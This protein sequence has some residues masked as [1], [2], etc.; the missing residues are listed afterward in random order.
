MVGKK[1][2]IIMVTATALIGL[3]A[4]SALVQDMNSD[5]TAHGVIVPDKNEADVGENITF[6][7]QDMGIG[8]AITTHFIVDFHDGTPPVELR[9]EYS[10]IHS[11]PF[12]G[13]YGITMIAISPYG[14]TETTSANIDIVNHR[15]AV[16]IVAPGSAVEDENITLSVNPFINSTYPDTPNDVAGLK[17]QWRYGD[18]CFG[19]GNVTTKSYN[20]SG[21]YP[22]AV[23]VS[24][25]QGAIGYA[26][27]TI[28]INNI[29][30]VANFTWSPGTIIEDS[31]I[32]FDARC[33]TDTPSD[34]GSLAYYWDFGDGHVDKNILVY[35]TFL[36]SGT[37]PV[38]LV[39]ID[40]D[41]A[42]DSIVKQVTVVNEL[43]TSHMENNSLILNEGD[44]GI[45]AV[46]ANDTTSD[47]NQMAYSWSTGG[48]GS[49]ATQRYTDEWN[50]NVV[51]T[52]TDPAG[53]QSTATT[54]VSVLNTNPVIMVDS[55]NM[56]GNI[57]LHMAGTMNNTLFMRIIKNGQEQAVTSLVRNATRTCWDGVSATLPMNFDLSQDWQVQVFYGRLNQS[58]VSKSTGV[59]GANDLLFND[60]HNYIATGPASGARGA[61]PAWLEFQFKDGVYFTLFHVFW[62]W[63]NYSWTWNISPRDYLAT[64]TLTILGHVLDR[65]TDVL[66]ARVT[67]GNRTAVFNA[68]APTGMLN[69][70]FTI[71]GWDNWINYWQAKWTSWWNHW[72][73]FW[74][75]WDDDFDSWFS[76][77]W[78]MNSY[79]NQHSWWQSCSS[80]WDHDSC[81]INHI[82]NTQWNDFYSMWECGWSCWWGVDWCDLADFSWKPIKIQAWDDDGGNGILNVTMHSVNGTPVIDHLSPRVS[83]TVPG[84]QV[85]EDGATFFQ[86]SVADYCNTS[87]PVNPA[88]LQCSWNFGDGT[89]IA[90]NA[91]NATHAW[92][93]AGEYMVEA[94]VSDGY[95]RGIDRAIVT[96][97]D[98]QPYVIAITG[99]QNLTVDQLAN[100]SVAGNIID[101]PSD[102][103]SLRCIWNF[104]DGTFATGDA[105]N[106]SWSSPGFYTITALAIDNN[107][108]VGKNNLSIHVGE[109]L[110]VVS[111]PFGIDTTQEML[112]N[113]NITYGDTILNSQNLSFNW[114]IDGVSY[115]SPR[116]CAVLD[117]GMHNGTFT[118]T[119]PAGEFTTAN[120]NIHVVNIIP[121]VI[122]QDY[123]FYQPEGPITLTAYGLDA[124]EDLGTLSY[125]WT[126]NGTFT[127]VQQGGD[128]SIISWT[129]PHSGTYDCRV[130]V[131]DSHG[132]TTDAQF[133][134]HVTLD[135]D[136][137]GVPN[138][139]EAAMGTNSSSP[140][141]DGDGLS[142]AYEINYSHT[143]PAL[144]DTDGDGLVDGYDPITNTGEALLGTNPLCNDTDG[145][146]LTDGFEVF[147]WNITIQYANGSLETRHVTSDPLK[148]DTDGDGLTDYQEWV[149]HTDPRSWDTNHD[150]IS[151]YAERY[152]ATT[153]D[154]DHDG[155]PDVK[156]L[157]GFNLRLANGTTIHVTSDPTKNDT[158]GDGLSDYEEWYPGADG[159]ITNPSCNDTDHDG[160]LDSAEVFSKAQEYGVRQKIPDNTPTNFHFTA[161]FGNNLKNITVTFGATTGEGNKADFHAIVTYQGITVVD[162]SSRGQSYY[163]N[164]TDVTRKTNGQA[165]GLWQIQITTHGSDAMLELFKVEAAVQLSP[166]DN[167]TDHDGLTDG[168][169]LKGTTGWYT[170]P[171]LKDTD[172]D[173]W[174]DY[175]EIY[176]THTNPLAI[177]TDG[178]GVPDSNDVDPLRNV[179][180]K[181]QVNWGRWGDAF[182][183]DIDLSNPELAVVT[184]VGGMS[185][186]TSKQTTTQDSKYCAIYGYYWGVTDTHGSIWPWQW[187]YGWIR[188]TVSSW[189]I[190][191]EAQYA[192]T[193][194]YFDIP[195]SAKT[196]TISS[197]LW[198]IW[199]YTDDVGDQ[200]LP[201]APVQ[202]LYNVGTTNH[203]ANLVASSG[204]NDVGYTVT[205][206]GLDKVNTIAVY[207]N[208]SSFVNNHYS[209]ICQ[210]NLIMLDITSPASSFTSETR[211]KPGLNVIVVPTDI[212]SD[213]KLH[214][215]IELAINDSTGYLNRS[216]LPSCLQGACF[217]GIDRSKGSISR[218]VE[219]IIN[220]TVTLATANSI[221]ALILTSA[222]N[223]SITDAFKAKRV[224]ACTLGIASDVLQLIPWNGAI[225]QYQTTP[226]PMPK[227]LIG[228]IEQFFVSLATLV[229]GGIVAIVGFLVQLITLIVQ[230]GMSIVGQITAMI[231]KAVM[232]AIEAIVKALV[233]AF[234]YL[235][236]AFTLLS[237]AGL[238]LVLIP[239]FAFINVM[240]QG[241]YTYSIN[242]LKIT[243]DS[244]FIS[245]EY[246]I[247]MYYF[248][249]LDISIPNISFSVS[250]QK[251]GFQGDMN[252]FSSFQGNISSMMTPF[253]PD[254]GISTTPESN[255]KTM[256][257][258]LIE[259]DPPADENAYQDG[260]I[261]AIALFGAAMIIL[262][263]IEQIIS[264]ANR[265][266]EIAAFI[267]T[268]IALI[269][270][271]VMIHKT[272]TDEGNTGFIHG[273]S[274]G[275]AI[276]ILLMTLCYALV[277]ARSKPLNEIYDKIVTFISGFYIFSDIAV[278]LGFQAGNIAPLIIDMGAV[279]LGAV[280]IACLKEDSTREKL[281]GGFY[282]ASILVCIIFLAI[283]AGT[284]TNS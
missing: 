218:H 271:I 1:Q 215:V 269:I 234:V 179:M 24:D 152:N 220:A 52:V 130:T 274:L 169:E 242:S 147:G 243:K 45:F 26:S 11:F 21:M 156:E 167:D 255:V 209:S 10:V 135:N 13:K 42:K 197:Q 133:F 277:E 56:I 280:I 38:K 142:D 198:H 102:M 101:T 210:E 112:I 185:V 237:I 193:F 267:I 249:P 87:V 86:V 266:Y 6:Y 82:F 84:Y 161:N 253:L 70:T 132:D 283:A 181:V 173:G 174:S 64:S 58:A 103:P 244:T 22:V 163:F 48:N 16:D 233:L 246:D 207:E 9:Q 139:L 43:P 51:A 166:I 262:A 265:G 66:S 81:F 122:I 67:C 183:R 59:P 75:N 131:T 165:N 47:I 120:V 221:L 105:V 63:N 284:G 247:N 115:A 261:F 282:L 57:T 68:T 31:S 216:V 134:V 180:I 154:T 190:N 148:V 78:A 199:Q 99:L 208:E 12:E 171:S 104:D 98:R 224:N 238:F 40:N 3:F 214:K 27:T 76:Y 240:L 260:A 41:N 25:D 118:I 164:V 257:T 192:N 172:G 88:T 93:H 229:W 186:A 177:D 250:T 235:M 175:K 125:N 201:N 272:L 276:V 273:M 91:F 32:L 281:I 5:V 80:R 223:E 90:G 140:D 46:D 107:G 191:T 62:V 188:F 143:N 170:D 176:Q 141:S 2:A 117:P 77:W 278:L 187:S 241:D 178:D 227:T 217:D 94:T 19:N 279:F 97:A 205:T 211:F 196:V 36:S 96:V 206:I 106:H 228:A 162:N 200:V 251:G 259:S 113:Y 226:G 138:E 184:T 44:T 14:L 110:P 108:I 129:P 189:S 23:Y 65:G 254:L 4:V 230:W 195:D 111:G 202:V 119:N 204:N 213:T 159:Y 146:N 245:M 182:F 128:R 258:G 222:S 28:Q 236:F 157:A 263:T 33:T 92:A 151:D 8:Q 160:V 61:N 55:V 121:T 83:L 71:H 116:L 95:S 54:A 194:F 248:A 60:S 109:S 144:K 7:I 72:N 137:D 53:L 136:E 225:L 231:A 50:G 73:E 168:Q 34:V 17:Y 126:M 20:Q 123:M 79:Q 219:S 145:D 39:V 203:T 49:T 270:G 256:N 35:H 124:I 89:I 264:G 127:V 85:Y 153:I 18:G 252:S 114:N 69:F 149:Y 239:V 15:P 74:S 30:P 212:Y 100:F 29:P 232:A 275:F 155:I 268:M 150:G 158:D 37:F